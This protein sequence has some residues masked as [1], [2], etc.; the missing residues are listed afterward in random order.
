M[1]FK[2]VIEDVE[3]GYLELRQAT[4][5]VFKNI[6]TVTNENG[7]P[8]DQENVLTLKSSSP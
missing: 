8:S 7:R 2:K 6:A 3:A 1:E 5:I 4:K